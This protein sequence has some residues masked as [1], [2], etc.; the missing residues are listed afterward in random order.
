MSNKLGN[1]LRIELSR[2]FNCEND[3]RDFFYR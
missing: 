2:R 3:F 1:D